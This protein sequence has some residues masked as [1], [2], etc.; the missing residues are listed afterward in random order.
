[1]AR[2]R[3]VHPGQWTDEAFVSVSPL[4]R[5]VAI[6]LRNEADDGG[7]FAWRPLQIRM[8]LLPADSCDIDELLAELERVDLIKRYEVE[9]KA[10]GAI[11]NFQVFQR[12]QKP[13]ETHPRLPWVAEYTGSVKRELR[14]GY[15][16]GTGEL[17]DGS[18]NLPPDGIGEDSKGERKNKRGADA[19]PPPSAPPQV[20]GRN[21]RSPSDYAFHGKV[22]RLTWE[23]FGRWSNGYANL[24][25]RAKLQQ[26]DDWYSETGEN[27]KNWFVRTSN[28]LAGENSKAGDKRAPPQPARDELPL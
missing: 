15:D 24:D 9:G 11:R 8:R 10:F 27:P 14:D 19:P 18:G 25:L 23:D 13:T 7:V 28:W 1:M 4:A 17:G 21:G 22:I 26:R 16:S 20:K 12:P 5:L 6:G 3:S 2:I